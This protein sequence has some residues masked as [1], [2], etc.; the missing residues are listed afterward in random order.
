MKQK[1]IWMKHSVI[2]LI[3]LF[4]LFA[5]N[6]KV[7][8]KVISDYVYV[9]QSNH[10]LTLHCYYAG[11]DSSYILN[12]ASEIKFR[13][14]LMSGSSFL[15]IHSDSV[16]IIYDSTKYSIVTKFDKKGVLGLE[17]Y[18]YTKQEENHHLY[19]FVV[20]EEM[21]NYAKLLK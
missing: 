4:I 9:N 21:Y 19:K 18:T 2:G 1:T 5:C 17:N 13:E 16:K 20:N 8:N 6:D 14:D 15:I 7:D 10:N 11:I 12:N 3:S